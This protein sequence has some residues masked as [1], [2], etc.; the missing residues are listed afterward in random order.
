[1]EMRGHPAMNG[2]AHILWRS[3]K[4]REKNEL[5]GGPAMTHAIVEVVVIALEEHG[6]LG[7]GEG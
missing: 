1:M 3:N 4:E 5:R 7:E 6:H 2:V